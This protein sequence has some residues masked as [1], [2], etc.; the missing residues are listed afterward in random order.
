M[1]RRQ[2]RKCVEKIGGPALTLPTQLCLCYGH[3]F[4]VGELEKPQ[5]W[6]IAWGRFKGRIMA[7]YVAA[8]PGSRPAACYLLGEIAP[9]RPH[10]TEILRHPVKVGGRSLDTALHGWQEECDHLVALGLLT[11]REIDEAN[12]RL[13]SPEPTSWH[14]MPQVAS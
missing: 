6:A 3:S 7:E 13:D 5:D 1:P 14:R 2:P 8:Y 9:Y 10:P 4:D 12:A 11:D